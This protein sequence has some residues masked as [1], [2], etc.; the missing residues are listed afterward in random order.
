MA[1]ARPE[2]ATPEPA[3]PEPA[4]PGPAGEGW[5]PGAEPAPPAPGLLLVG[6]DAASAREVAGGL[7]SP[8][9][10]DALDRPDEALDRLAA[11]AVGVLCLG[12]GVAG[13]AA[14]RLL[15]RAARASLLDGVVCVVLAGGSDLD[16]FQELVDD[17]R[18]YYLTRRPP[19]VDEVRRILDGAAAVVRSPAAGDGRTGDDRTGDD[20]LLRLA[21]PL[22]AVSS[23]EEASRLL[24]EA[25]EAAVAPERCWCWLYD[26]VDELLWTPQGRGYP[27][28]AV[29]AASGLAGYVLRTGSPVLLERV[30]EDPRYDPEADNDGGPPGE[31]FLAVPVVPPP[32]GA[33]PPAAALVMAVLV[34]L[35]PPAGAPFGRRQQS[36]LEFLAAQVAAPLQRLTLAELAAKR[37]LLESPFRRQA[38]EERDRGGS[39]LGRPLEISPAW[40]R[41]ALPLLLPLVLTALAFL[42]FGTV[43]DYARGG[44]LV[45]MGDRIEVSATTG[46]TV[47]ALHVASGDLVRQG[48]PL[49]SLDDAG[50]AAELTRLEGEVELALIER[51]RRPTDPATGRALGSLVHQR[52]LAEQRWAERTLV[53]PAAG[54]VGEIRVE[55]GQPVAPGQTVTALQAEDGAPAP[56]GRLVALFPGH[57]RPLLEPGMPLLLELDGYPGARQEL[58]IARVSDGLVGPA[59]ARRI[60]GSGLGDA[61]P[62]AGTLVFVVAELPSASFRDDDRTR[63]YHEGM[64]GSAEVRVRSDRVLFALLPGLEKALDGHG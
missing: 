31:R 28:R 11:G 44:A 52:G 43:H 16:L 39:R 2:P 33:S 49:V 47:A 60:L 45:R 35:R 57:Y 29:S 9:P 5:P 1:S 62:L 42:A 54:R 40:T 12:A 48:D 34:A 26:P 7:R 19:R 17:D 41:R 46:G 64:T 32:A 61:L 3:T 6:F 21:D 22:A 55:P 23:L 15:D 37:R 56:A 53:A 20:L 24:A 63:R 8:L 14:R 58:A 59:E 51:L 10:V 13:A 4:A 30:G 38:V 25:A 27:A 18:L 36:I 50:E